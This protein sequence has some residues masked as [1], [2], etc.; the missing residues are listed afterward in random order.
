[1]KNLIIKFLGGYTESQVKK[2]KIESRKHL[3]RKGDLVYINN[4]FFDP[5]K[6]YYLLESYNNGY[7][8]YVSQNQN[9]LT[10]RELINGVIVEHI[11]FEPID[12]CKFCHSK[13]KT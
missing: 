3:F 2:Q 9:D 12:F 13:I 7:C 10:R 1:M 4:D 5:T 11:Q 8:W 6:K